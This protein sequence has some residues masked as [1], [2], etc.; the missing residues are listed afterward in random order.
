MRKKILPV[1]LALGLMFACA[2]GQAA[3]EEKTYASGGFTYSLDKYDRATVLTTP[4]L[5]TDIPGLWLMPPTLD[6]HPLQ[7]LNPSCVPEDID[8]ILLPSRC[9]LNHRQPFTHEITVYHYL[10][11]DEIQTLEW[12]YYPHVS[13]KPGEMLLSGKMIRY[14]RDGSWDTLTQD[15]YLYP[16]RVNGIKIWHNIAPESVTTYTSGEYSYYKLSPDTVNICRYKDDEIRK[17]RVPETLDGM[18]VVSIAGFSGY[19]AAIDTQLA[20]EIL[21]PATLKTI[22]TTAIFS[23]ELKS[24]TL[25]EGLE[26]IGDLA[27]HAGGITKITLPSSLRVIGSLFLSAN[28]R[29]LTVPDG[30]EEIRYQAFQNLDLTTLTLPVS[31]REIPAKMCYRQ[32]QLTKVT[33]PASV[34]SIGA[35]AFE[36]CKKLKQV[37]MGAGV[38]QIDPT[39]FANG[40]KKLT[41]IAPKGS[42]AETFAK[43]NG[44]SFKKGK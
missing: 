36:G 35:S 30:V 10:D 16:T 14:R 19:G 34:T 31:I 2:L 3:G 1:L 17:V 22:G 15:Y 18:T 32:D 27:I 5:G 11:F 26:E 13:V 6:G 43:K 23:N 4:D 7:Y 28:V 12:E 24:L 20:K 9:Y 37:T 39:A 40:G 44:Y 25:P 41:I 8:A 33:I 38:E 21:L 42:Y 29:K